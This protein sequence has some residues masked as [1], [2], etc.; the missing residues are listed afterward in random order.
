MSSLAV[1]QQIPGVSPTNRYTTIGPL[2]LVLLAS[3]FKEVEEDMVFVSSTT[4]LFL[5]LMQLR[6]NDINLTLN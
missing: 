5:I 6:R 1:I 2:A 4:D 3:A